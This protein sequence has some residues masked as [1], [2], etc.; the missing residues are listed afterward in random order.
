[1]GERES[2]ETQVRGGVRDRAEDE[3]DHLDQL[4]DHDLAEAAVVVVRVAFFLVVVVPRVDQLRLQRVLLRVRVQ[5][6]VAL[7][8]LVRVCFRFH[9]EEEK[10]RLHEEHHWSAYAGDY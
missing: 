4:V 10:Q 1:V 5:R 9:R 3:L 2:P 6:D 7:W 8:R